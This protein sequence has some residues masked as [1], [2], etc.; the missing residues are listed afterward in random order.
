MS[1]QLDLDAY[2]D[3][4]GAS[5]RDEGQRRAFSLADDWCDRAFSQILGWVDEG[6]EFEP[7]DLRAAL[8]PAPSSGAPGAVINKARKAGLISSRGFTISR[9][10][11]RHGGVA[12]RWGPA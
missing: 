11:S 1:E 10:P 9:A 3:R 4:M 7:D 8:G 2:R 12:R 6:L 5:A